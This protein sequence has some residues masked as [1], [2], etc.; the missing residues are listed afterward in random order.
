[1]GVAIILGSYLLKHA[2]G[3]NGIVESLMEEAR[4]LE[5]SGERRSRG[6]GK[7]WLG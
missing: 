5:A 7:V 3:V 6:Q 1:M 4:V 2:I